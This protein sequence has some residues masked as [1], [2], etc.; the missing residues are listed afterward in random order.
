MGEIRRAHVLKIESARLEVRRNFFTV[1]AAK[2]WN[3][4]P[5][6]VQNQT[7]VNGFKKAYDAWSEISSKERAKTVAR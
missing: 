1:R 5:G 6:H 2:A 4:I 7:S 3:E